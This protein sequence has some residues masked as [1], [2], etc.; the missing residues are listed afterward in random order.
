MSEPTTAGKGLELGLTIILCAALVVATAVLMGPLVS[1]T[2][3]A[4]MREYGL[5]W[6][7]RA[8]IDL[9]I[10]LVGVFMKNAS[11]FLLICFGLSALFEGAVLDLLFGSAPT[12]A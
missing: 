11:G 8:A 2:F 6:I 5:S 7:T 3:V 4:I 9:I 10:V 12:S 1:F